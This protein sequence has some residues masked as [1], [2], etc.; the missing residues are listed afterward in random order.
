MWG[1]R[2]NLLL[3]DKWVGKA[4]KYIMCEMLCVCALVLQTLIKPGGSSL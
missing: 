1:L 3:F 4:N 2:T